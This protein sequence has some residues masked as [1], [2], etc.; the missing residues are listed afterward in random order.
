[1]VLQL[2]ETVYDPVAAAASAIPN[3]P[4]FAPDETMQQTHAGTIMLGPVW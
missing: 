2:F 3:C 4:T 1:M